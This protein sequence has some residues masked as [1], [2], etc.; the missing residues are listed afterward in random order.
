MPALR[1]QSTSLPHRKERL[2]R[3]RHRSELYSLLKNSILRLP[4]GGAA[5]YRCDTALFSVPAS[6]AEGDCGAH[7]EF[8][9][10][11]CNWILDRLRHLM[12]LTPRD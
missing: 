5:V 2:H 4:L 6:A 3:L 12:G 9:S 8:F 10:K 11:L 7:Q 1:L